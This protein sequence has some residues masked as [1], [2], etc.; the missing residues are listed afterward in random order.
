MTA[1][2]HLFIHFKVQATKRSS[3]VLV[4]GHSRFLGGAI[5]FFDVALHTGG[6]NILPTVAPAP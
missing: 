5:A 2:L 3:W 4:Q 6:N 1:I